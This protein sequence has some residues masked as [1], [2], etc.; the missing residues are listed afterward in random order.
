MP[1]LVLSLVILPTTVFAQDTTSNAVTTDN[2]QV[3]S[4][5][6]NTAE[7]TV[8]EHPTYVIYLHE[9]CPHCKKVEAYVAANNL[10]DNI[11]YKQL[12]NNDANMAE[13]EALWE[14]LGT[15]Q[16]GWPFL[17][18]QGNKSNYVGGD[19]PIISL[20]ATEFGLEVPVESSQETTTQSTS[21]SDKVFFLIGG[22]FVVGFIGYAIYSFVKED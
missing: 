11:I 22:I 19:T 9:D 10:Q 12:K 2:A 3:D 13:L 7:Q 14:E 6:T 16:T 18:E 8:V 15:D 1:L 20:L 5:N 17:V 4:T 21:E